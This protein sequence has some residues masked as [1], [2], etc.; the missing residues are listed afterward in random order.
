MKRRILSIIF[1]CDLHGTR[2]LLGLVELLFAI[3]LFFAYPFDKSPSAVMNVLMNKDMWTAI[4]AIMGALQWFVLLSQNY[5]SRFAVVFAAFNS[6]IWWLT[7]LALIFSSV[8]MFEVV[9][10]IG[11]AMSASWIFVRSGMTHIDHRKYDRRAP[12]DT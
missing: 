2:F 8:S 5:H 4:F 9:S 1:F 3:T 7:T 10:E 6:V 11:L 12:N